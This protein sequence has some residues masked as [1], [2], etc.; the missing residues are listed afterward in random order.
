MFFNFRKTK[1]TISALILSTFFTFSQVAFAS[2][3]GYKKFCDT[4]TS[5][6]GFKDKNGKIVIPA[7]FDS[8]SNFSE[9]LAKVGKITPTNKDAAKYGFINTSGKIVIPMAFDSASDFSGG[10]A[11]VS[12]GKYPNIKNFTIN[13]NGD[14]VNK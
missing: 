5:K 4:K 12:Q 1:V 9:D 14:I 11:Q 13:K 6:C 3:L 10:F 8:V 2:D 7:T